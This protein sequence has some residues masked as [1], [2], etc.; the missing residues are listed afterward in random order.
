M[1]EYKMIIGNLKNFDI[2]LEILKFAFMYKVVFM[3]SKDLVKD[4]IYFFGWIWNSYVEE[5]KVK[6]VL[7]IVWSFKVC[8][9][10]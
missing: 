10:I 3:F 5:V 4:K 6:I 2:F 7:L 1:V 9:F 8:F